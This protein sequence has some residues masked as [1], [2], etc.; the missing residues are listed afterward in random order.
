M[1]P[2]VSVIMPCW[3]AV[4]T[5]ERAVGSVLNSE[6]KE[7]ELIVADDGS[8]D[9][10]LSA[11]K[12][13]ELIYD[14]LVVLRCEHKGVSAARNAALARAK[15]KYI[16]FIDA[17]DEYLPATLPTAVRAVEAA[18]AD[19]AIF[20]YY[21]KE[22][23]EE[24]RLYPIKCEA[25]YTTNEEIREGY[26]WRLFGCSLDEVRA[27]QYGLLPLKYGHVLGG[28]WCCVFRRDLIER[29]NLRFDERISLYED[30]FFNCEYLLH[31]Q[32][33]IALEQPLY[34]Y[35][36]APTGSMLRQS[37]GIE[38]M[39]AKMISLV[40]RV[41]IDEQCGGSLAN[42][43]VGSCVFSL[44]QM[45]QIYLKLPQADRP[46]AKNLIKTYFAHPQVRAALKIFPLSWRHPLV[47]LA[48]G[49]LRHAH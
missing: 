10:T 8:S 38:M 6:F 20:P 27:W 1:T 44:L 24:D 48:V 4:E 17:D 13:Y 23:G 22:P 19:Y 29:Y 36:L 34:R 26:L 3:N 49:I 30:A 45:L 11:L 37:H 33:M 39:R 21:I 35:Y 43:Y 2:I 28:V 47:S 42:L 12:P 46:E 25:K 7:V 16:M 5:I 41:E 40:K 14:G 32:S 15:G 9:E 18:Q 31:A